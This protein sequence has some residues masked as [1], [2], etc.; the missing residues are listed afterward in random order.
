MES[1]AYGAALCVRVVALRFFLLQEGRELTRGAAFLAGAV[2]GVAVEGL[3]L[4]DAEGDVVL[5]RD[6]CN[7]VARRS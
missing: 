6:A 3:S 2:E 5:R 7:L 4:W 1:L